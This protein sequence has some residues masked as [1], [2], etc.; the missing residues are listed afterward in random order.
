MRV[1]DD[2]RGTRAVRWDASGTTATELGNLGTDKGGSTN[3]QAYAI[4]NSGVIVGYANKY[5]AAGQSLGGRAVLWNAD[6]V[7]IDLGSLVD[8][9]SGWTLNR[10]YAISDTNWVTGIGSFDPGGSRDPYARAFL[11]DVSG[12][13]TAPGSGGD[14]NGNGIVDAADYTVWRATL[15]STTDL[16]ADG[17]NTGTSA[18]VIDQADFEFWR[19]HYG[20]HAG[21]GA[22]ATAAV[23][24]PAT[25]MLLVLPLAVAAVRNAGR[26]VKSRYRVTCRKPSVF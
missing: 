24:E 11:I 25:V 23:P 22:G 13:V 20:N 6:G 17:D 16:R 26:R 19:S 1:T 7:A 18:G 12:A 8:P 2:F 21:S 9:N 10:V 4:N 15:G 14:Y 5:D 3:A